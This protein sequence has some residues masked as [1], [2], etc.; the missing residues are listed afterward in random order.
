MAEGTNNSQSELY[1][2]SLL[3]QR[4]LNGLYEKY[5]LKEE[6]ICNWRYSGGDR[7]PDFNYFKLKYPNLSRPMHHFNC[8]C[9][10]SI[11]VNCYI[12]HINDKTGE[13]LLVVG[14]CCI[15]KFI[16]E[17]KHRTCENCGGKHKRRKINICQNCENLEKEKKKKRRNN[18]KFYRP[19][20]LQEEISEAEDPL[21]LILYKLKHLDY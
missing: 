1:T 14:S 18:M 7:G 19:S 21:E 16:A 17:G 10:Q 9:G 5:R 6:D 4:F 15:R 12:S 8:V 3:S 13:T 2:N 11:E 20:P